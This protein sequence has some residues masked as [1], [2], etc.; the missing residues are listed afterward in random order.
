[1]YVYEELDQ[2]SDQEKKNFFSFFL[3]RFLG[4]EGIFF[5]LFFLIAFFVES[6]F[7]LY[8]FPPQHGLH[9]QLFLDML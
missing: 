1:M 6:V 2:E 3:G 7:F 5:Y 8:K 4:R 9:L